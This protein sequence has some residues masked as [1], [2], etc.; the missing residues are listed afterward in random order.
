[1]MTSLF[2]H[3]PAAPEA[4]LLQECSGLKKEREQPRLFPFVKECLPASSA[5]GRNVNLNAAIAG[6]SRRGVI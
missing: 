5:P 2:D 4:R 1:M 6:L 3:K